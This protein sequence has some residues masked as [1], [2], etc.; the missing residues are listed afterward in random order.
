M[1]TDCKI[2]YYAYQCSFATWH[3]LAIRF[4]SLV[5]H[6]KG[7]LQY[8]IIFRVSENDEDDDTEPEEPVAKKRKH[9]R[10]TDEVELKKKKLDKLSE[11]KDKKRKR[12][13][14]PMIPRVWIFESY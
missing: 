13:K 1:Q 3:E 12:K 9:D 6:E 10:K 14:V 4:K 2:N 5:R 11:V 7:Q 8:D